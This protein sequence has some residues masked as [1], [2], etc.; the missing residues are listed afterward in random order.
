MNSKLNEIMQ[1]MYS[2]SNYFFQLVLYKLWTLHSNLFL[3]NWIN[4]LSSFL[5][6]IIVC[7][8]LNAPTTSRIINQYKNYK[9]TK[10]LLIDISGSIFNH[11]NLLYKRFN[12]SQYDNLLV[13]TILTE[14][15]KFILNS[16]YH[17]EF[18]RYLSIKN[19]MENGANPVCN[20]KDYFE[21]NRQMFINRSACEAEIR[22][23]CN[24]RRQKALEADV[25][26][27]CKLNFT[28]NS[29]NQ[30]DANPI[31]SKIENDEFNKQLIFSEFFNLF[32]FITSMVKSSVVNDTAPEIYQFD[33]IVLD[34]KKIM[35][36]NESI[37]IWRPFMILQQNEINKNV[38]IMHH[39]LS[40]FDNWMMKTTGRL[41]DCG[42]LCWAAI[43]IA[44]LLLL[45]IVGVSSLSAAV[46]AR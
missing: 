42:V 32:D 36:M 22:S 7:S 4:T 19:R 45:C 34:F 44:L 27:A 21:K 2:I 9:H 37:I 28:E 25:T 16:K 5:L 26:V 14:K 43:A 40:E 20:V 29:T 33:F 35:S 46:A 15:F 13:L 31:L 41:W 23:F 11:Q 3:I 30:S 8:P 1:T 6:V 10:I 17:V 12:V 24:H 38:F 18:S 39:A